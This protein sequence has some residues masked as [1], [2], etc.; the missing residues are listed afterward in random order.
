VMQMHELVSQISDA[1]LKL[2]LL[3]QLEQFTQN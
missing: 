2:Q 3:K 1:G